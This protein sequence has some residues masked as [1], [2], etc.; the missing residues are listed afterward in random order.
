MGW[1]GSVFEGG[2]LGGE[3]ELAEGVEGEAV[4][5]VPVGVPG[6]G[7]L[8]LGHVGGFLAE[9]GGAES[10]AAEGGVV[11]GQLH[12]GIGEGLGEGV[13]FILGG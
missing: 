5:G 2:D 3:A 7:E 1:R 8:V 6:G 11:G 4:E 12:P 13:V 9:S 10:E